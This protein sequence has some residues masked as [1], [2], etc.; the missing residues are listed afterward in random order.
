[1]LIY[2]HFFQNLVYNFITYFSNFLI[3]C[4]LHCLDWLSLESSQYVWSK[5]YCFFF[6]SP[7]CLLKILFNEQS[8]I[9]FFLVPQLLADFLGKFL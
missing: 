9:L 5:I 3:S 1:M 2:D 4:V 8:D 7:N 6:G